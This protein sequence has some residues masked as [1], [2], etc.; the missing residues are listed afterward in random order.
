MFPAREDLQ[1]LVRR[2]GRIVERARLVHEAGVPV[3]AI[4]TRRPTLDDVYLRL[5]GGRLGG[6]E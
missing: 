1:R 2:R 3:N 5:T 4:A 6:A